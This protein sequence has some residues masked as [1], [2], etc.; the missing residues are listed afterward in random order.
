VKPAGVLAS[1]EGLIATC[2]RWCWITTFR[3]RT[4]RSSC[5]SGSVSPA[6]RGVLT[7]YGRVW[8]SSTSAQAVAAKGYDLVHAP[9]DY[10]YLDCGQGEW[11]GNTSDAWVPPSGS[12]SSSAE[13]SRARSTSW[14]DPFKGWQRAYT[15]DP[16]ANLTAAEAR[17]VRGGQQLLWTEQSDPANLD[18][19]V[20][21][22]AA[23]SAGAPARATAVRAVPLT[24]CARG[25]ALLVRAGDDDERDRGA[26]AP[27]RAALP[28][29]G[30]RDASDRAPAQMVCAA[31]GQVRAERVKGRL[32]GKTPG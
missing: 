1:C 16:R 25:R 13:H 30:A 9:S 28:H 27:A 17:R 15:F 2:Q 22:R 5:A 7:V 4:I 21:P 26:A 32:A 31:P 8:I 19:Q 20:W 11:I 10:F 6:H 24:V 3:S 14:C 12:S 29:G 18:P 23:V